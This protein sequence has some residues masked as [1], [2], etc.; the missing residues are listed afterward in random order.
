MRNAGITGAYRSLLEENFYP[1][2]DSFYRP[3]ITTYR[4][5]AV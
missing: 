3:V 4:P 1:V 5:L 2:V